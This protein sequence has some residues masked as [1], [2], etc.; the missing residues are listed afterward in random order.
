VSVATSSSSQRSLQVVT[1]AIGRVEI[2]SMLG[3][4]GA[5]MARGRVGESDTSGRVCLEQVAGKL[6]ELVMQR[7]HRPV[8]DPFADFF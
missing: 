1:P 7:G 6:R 4:S 3:S 2:A 8:H 5:R